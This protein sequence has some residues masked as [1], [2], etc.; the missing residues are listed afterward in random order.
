MITRLMH[1]N[2]VCSDIE[3]SLRFYRDILGAKVI[4]AIGGGESVEIGRALGFDGPVLFRAYLLAFGE[5]SKTSPST[6]I[7]LLQ[8]SEPLG[9]DTLG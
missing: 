6:L 2:V 7:D 3:E 4:P 1:V 9:L 8:W 5:G